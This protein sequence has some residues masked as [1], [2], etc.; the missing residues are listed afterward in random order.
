MK[1][2]KFIQLGA[3][4][5]AVSALSPLLA[6]NTTSPTGT[7]FVYSDRY[8]NHIINT[9]H[10][11]SPQRLTAI[12]AE[13]KQR[14][15]DKNLISISPLP[16]P[17]IHIEQ[18]HTQSHIERIQR[19][20]V[21]GAIAELAVAGTLGAVKAVAE[22][23]VRN[24]F[25]A[26]RPP[27]HHARNSGRPEGFCYYGNVAIAARYAQHV[28][29]LQ[30]ILIIDWDYHHGNGTEEFFYEDPSVLFF[31]THNARAYPGTGAP[32]RTGAGE[33]EGYTINVHLECGATEYDMLKKWDQR[34]MPAVERFR[35][36]LVLIS[37][38]FDSRKN[39]TLG[40]FAVSD[41]G[42]MKLT[43]RAMEIA[44]TYANGRLVSVLE[45]G[46]NIPGLA[47]ATCAHLRTLSTGDD[48]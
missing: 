19:I 39:D 26:I 40:C 36:D 7:G 10:P 30:K 47:K 16:K 24:A 9:N 44:D 4:G 41:I 48:A 46:Y 21:S 29:G 13:M 22:K 34:L 32:S 6:E 43:K 2:R 38:G 27:G 15:L 18:L 33:G 5:V 11:E 35:P 17:I 3:Q 20:K 25:C 42:F 1:R 45:G 37:A 28:C 12:R 8:L 23:R 31:S 14:E